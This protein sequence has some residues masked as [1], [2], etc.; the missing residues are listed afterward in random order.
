MKKSIEYRAIENIARKNL[1]KKKK[2]FNV[3]PAVAFAIIVTAIISGSYLI[4][5]EEEPKEEIPHVNSLH[6]GTF[7]DIPDEL[8]KLSC[9]QLY[10]GILKNQNFCTSSQE[11]ISQ[12][13]ACKGKTLST[14]EMVDTYLNTCEGTTVKSLEKT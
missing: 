1:E 3:F 9:N 13:Q 10:V 6:Y 12:I 7:Y 11:F 4:L 8:Q 14:T 5:E 2:L